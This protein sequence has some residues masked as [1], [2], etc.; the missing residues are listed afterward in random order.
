MHN[1]DGGGLLAARLKR[2]QKEEADAFKDAMQ[3]RTRQPLYLKIKIRGCAVW[4]GCRSRGA[5][6]VD[7]AVPSLHGGG[8]GGKELYGR[9]QTVVGGDTRVSCPGEMPRNGEQRRKHGMHV[10]GCRRSQGEIADQ[11]LVVQ[12]ALNN[13][14]GSQE[15]PRLRLGRAQHARGPAPRQTRGDDPPT[16]AIGERRA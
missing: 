3:R 4:R 6:G 11:N 10:G 16:F 14:Q 13:L 1:D 7:E 2:E 15:E 9:S 8:F 5:R 12:N